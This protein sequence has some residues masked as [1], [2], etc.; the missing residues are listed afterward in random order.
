MTHLLRI[1]H[2]EYTSIFVFIFHIFLRIVFDLFIFSRIIPLMGVVTMQ[3]V[4]VH[5]KCVL[6]RDV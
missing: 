3:I 4:Y 6:L 1:F 2:D 5:G